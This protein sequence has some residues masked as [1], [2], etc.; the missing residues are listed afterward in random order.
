MCDDGDVDINKITE[1]LN[2]T[3]TKFIEAMDDDFNTSLALA[4]IFELVSCVN[5]EIADKDIC[6]DAAPVLNESVD[7]IVELMSVFGIDIMQ[8]A[9]S[10]KFPVELIALASKYGNYQGDDPQVAAQELLNARTL[11]REN[12]Q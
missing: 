5:S 10:K 7:L 3:K 4:E 1:K 11:A 12:K 9:D 2:E 6:S 8:D